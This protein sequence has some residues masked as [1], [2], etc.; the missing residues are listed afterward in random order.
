[1]N[2]TQ[3]LELVKEAILEIVPDADLTDVAPD[4]KFREV[5]ELDSLDFLSLV[6]RLA[7]RTGA[8]ID[9]EDYPAFATLT[10]ASE[11]LAEHA[12]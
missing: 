4:D 6:E 10:G 11:F 12:A 7:H 5:L 9:E 2:Q 8:R 1:M 3:A